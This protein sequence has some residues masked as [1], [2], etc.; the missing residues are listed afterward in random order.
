[1]LNQNLMRGVA[2]IAIALFFGVP[3]AGYPLGSFA[4]AGAGLFPLMI[5][6]VLGLIGL[7]MVVKSRF[8]APEA[9]HFNVRNMAI[10]LASLIGFVLIADHLKMLLAVVYLVFVS[11]LAGDGYSWRRNLKISAVLI[12][13]AFAFRYFLGLQLPLL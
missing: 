11:A 4:R 8:I 10:I 5:S 7:A 13:I 3:A 1:M 12:A 9:M 6:V 2:L